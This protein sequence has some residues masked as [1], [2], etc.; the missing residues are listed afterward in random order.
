MNYPLSRTLHALAAAITVSAAGAAVAAPE[1]LIRPAMPPAG[2]LR[3]PGPAVVDVAYA[4]IDPAGIE[5]QGVTTLDF[6]FSDAPFNVVWER[7][8]I[9]D[10]GSR[11]LTGRLIGEPSSRVYLT[12]NDGVVN[13]D[14]MSLQRGLHE[15]RY[16]GQGVHELRRLDER[17]L[18]SCG[19]TQAHAVAAPDLVAGE[20][21]AIGGETPQRA[22]DDGSLIDVL[23]GVT[24]NAVASFG[25]TI[26]AVEGFMDLWFEVTNDSYRNSNVNQR[27]RMV[28]LYEVDYTDGDAGTDLSR[29]RSSSDGNMDEVHGLRNQYG[30]D[31]CA[32]VS[33]SSG[34]CGIAYL[35]TN[36]SVGF[37]GSGFSVT[38]WSCGSLT[39]AHE[40]G[41]NM[42]SSHDHD[43]ASTGAYCHSFGYRTNDDRFRTIMAYAPGSRIPYFSNP[44][45]QYEDSLGILYQLGIGGCGSNAADN[46]L[47]LNNTGPTVA[48]FRSTMVPLPPPGEFAAVSPADEAEGFS[49]RGRLRWQPAELADTYTVLVSSNPDMSDPALVATGLESAEYNLPQGGLQSLQTYYWTVTAVNPDAT[50]DASTGVWSFSTA[51]LGDITGDNEVD[52]SDL[53]TLLTQFGL[54]GTGLTADVNGDGSVGFT[55]LNIVLSNFGEG[56]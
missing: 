31:L 32:L 37:Q 6:L 26:E 8:R 54:M 49:L 36:V 9:G 16:V 15:I 22:Y 25:G 23:V 3:D 39:F 29:W 50:T 41:H 10:A 19:T 5:R 53:N 30:A 38:N 28:H 42:G 44:E 17:E 46:T 21:D 27:V 51:V 7:E 4:A 52:F 35:M 24:P 13:A 47:S 33:T 45:V 12:I 2:D 48:Q 34:A 14:V 55:D 56:V 40:L 11:V 20:I 1:T 43:N 18:P